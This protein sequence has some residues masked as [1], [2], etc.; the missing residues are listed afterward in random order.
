M[1]PFINVANAIL[2]PLGFFTPSAEQICKFIFDLLTAIVD[3][4]PP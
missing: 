1:T 2:N 4:L 3:A